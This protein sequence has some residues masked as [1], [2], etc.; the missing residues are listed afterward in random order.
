MSFMGV[1]LPLDSIFFVSLASAVFICF[2]IVPFSILCF[3]ASNYFTEKTKFLYNFGRSMFPDN[4]LT[5]KE[6]FQKRKKSK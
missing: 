5:L 2:L 3:S 6:L 4:Y 1:D